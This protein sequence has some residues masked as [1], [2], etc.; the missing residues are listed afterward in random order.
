MFT[1][2]QLASI[3]QCSPQRAQRWHGP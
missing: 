1:D 2:T 3:M